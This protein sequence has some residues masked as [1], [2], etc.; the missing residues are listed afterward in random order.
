MR[1]MTRGSVMD[2]SPR[3]SLFFWFICFDVSPMVLALGVLRVLGLSCRD[4]VP[5]H[6][7][8]DFCKGRYHGNKGCWGS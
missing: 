1:L 3:V 8:T 4:L 6:L 2:C 5:H 7:P